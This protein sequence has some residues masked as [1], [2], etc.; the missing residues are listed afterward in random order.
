MEM[1]PTNQIIALA[2]MDRFLKEI[3]KIE[4]ML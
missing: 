4:I 1:S 3:D 2:E